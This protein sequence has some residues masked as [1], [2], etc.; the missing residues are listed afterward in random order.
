VAS[1][2]ADLDVRWVI[3]IFSWAILLQKPPPILVC[4]MYLQAFYG[5][6]V[7]FQNVVSY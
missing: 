2:F 4:A 6:N 5:D 1:S 7:P 3:V